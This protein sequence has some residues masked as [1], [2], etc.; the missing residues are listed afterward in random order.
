MRLGLRARLSLIVA[1]G[2]TV[3][4]TMAA[5]GLYWDTSDEVSDAITAELRVRMADLPAEIDDPAAG[6][7]T[8]RHL[9]ADQ[10][11]D[12]TGTVVSPRGETAILT[13]RELAAALDHELI[14]ERP[15]PGVGH[16][17]RIL[18]E[19]LG[20]ERGVPLVGVTATS[21]RPLVH[22]RDRLLLV[23]LVAT[24]LLTAAVTLTA[25]GLAGAALRPVS[26][27]AR[28]AETISMAAAG[29]RLPQPAGRDEIAD[30]GRR[31]NAMLARIETTVAHERAFVDDASHELR[32][33]LTVLRGELELAREDDEP[34]ALRR[35]VASALE[36]TDR[37]IGL[38]E[39][40]L[41]LAR[42]DAG[43]VPTTTAPCDLAAAAGRALDRLPVPAPIAASVHGEAASVDAPPEWI[44]QV[45]TNLLVNA[46]DHAAGA[47][48]VD[49][50]AD[51]GRVRLRVADDGPGFPAE[52]LPR[53]F[54]RFTRGDQSRGRGGTGLGLAIVAGIVRALGGE[55]E[56]GNGPPLGGARVEVTLPRRPGATG[57]PAA[58]APDSEP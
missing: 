16:D 22:V 15:V 4:S 14:V 43:Q 39:S 49:V 20:S 46:L 29:E 48:R 44:D 36:E 40:L 54:D 23:L 41:T 9:V 1:V 47:V 19:R 50:T 33:P 26:R 56:A 13:P 51:D 12:A 42:T 57:S 31:L 45:V 2:A 11:I 32:T 5:L 25:W 7:A 3:V 55:V 35:S 37:L 27:M 10:V 17:V 30:L 34:A 52:L 8:R 28:R 24:P 38:T 6:S 18:A 21:T 58:G 53:V